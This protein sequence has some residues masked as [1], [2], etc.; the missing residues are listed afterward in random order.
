MTYDK[1]RGAIILRAMLNKWRTPDDE[2]LTIHQKKWTM[3]RYYLHVLTGESP[4]WAVDMAEE[5]L[6]DALADE[7]EMVN[8]GRFES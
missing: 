6:Y 4:S 5:D 7:Q 1:D 2:P 3:E 8:E